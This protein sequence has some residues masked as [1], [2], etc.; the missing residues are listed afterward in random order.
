MC[1]FSQKI[2]PEFWEK[3]SHC[4]KPRV[5]RENLKELQWI[6]GGSVAG[7][8]II[9]ASALRL[10]GFRSGGVTA[11]SFAATW[12]SKIGSVAAGSLFATLQSLGATGLGTIMFG[13]IG[14][15]LGLLA[16]IASRLGWCEDNCSKP[17]TIRV[18]NDKVV[19]SFVLLDLN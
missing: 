18:E 15:A 11:K 12:Q 7:G 8:G 5:C 4:D 17:E 14:A 1:L 19:D 3:C 9:G 16:S 6:I 2:M 13:S 10:I